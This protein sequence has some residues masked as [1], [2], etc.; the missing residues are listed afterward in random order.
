MKFDI[1]TNGAFKKLNKM[2]TES[3]ECDKG[4]VKCTV[5]YVELSKDEQDEEKIQLLKDRSR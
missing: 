1:P 5:T 4:L 3:K 2:D